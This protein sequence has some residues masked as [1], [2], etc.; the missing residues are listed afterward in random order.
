[1]TTTKDHTNRGIVKQKKARFG[2]VVAI[3]EK[4]HAGKEERN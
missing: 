3:S 1:L 4:R 2:A